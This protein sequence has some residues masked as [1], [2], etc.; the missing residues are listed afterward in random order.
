MKKR[1]LRKPPRSSQQKNEKRLQSLQRRISVAGLRCQGWSV[2][3][4]A[5]E[6]SLTEDEV[7]QHIDAIRN[8]TVTFLW[9]S[10]VE[11]LIEGYWGRLDFVEKA[12]WKLAEDEEDPFLRRALYQDLLKTCHARLKETTS[13]IATLSSTLRASSSADNVPIHKMSREEYLRKLKEAIDRD[14]EEAA[15]LANEGRD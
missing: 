12:I 10:G 8:E 6:L 7:I 1:R 14:R 13:A 5:G 4:I 15:A 2:A 3:Q 11:H 9:N